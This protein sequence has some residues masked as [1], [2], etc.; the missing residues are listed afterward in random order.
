VRCACEPSLP[1]RRAGRGR[2]GRRLCAPSGDGSPARDQLPQQAAELV[3]ELCV[4]DDDVVPALIEDG[5]DRREIAP[6]NPG[7]F[8]W[9]VAAYQRSE[10]LPVTWVDRLG[11]RGVFGEAD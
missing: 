1:D 10:V 9:S 7:R 6:S 5:E 2:E 8:K 11:G 4:L 3:H